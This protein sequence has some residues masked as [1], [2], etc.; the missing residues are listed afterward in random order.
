MKKTPPS[1]TLGILEV[2]CASTRV[3]EL[4]PLWTSLTDGILML[5]LQADTYNEQSVLADRQIG[6]QSYTNHGNMLAHGSQVDQ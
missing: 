5:G 2:V 6:T 3:T 4:G 1:T